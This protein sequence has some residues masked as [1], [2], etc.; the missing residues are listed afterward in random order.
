MQAL[1]ET[2]A[3]QLSADF[4]GKTVG[5][6][7]DFG[8]TLTR[9]PFTVYTYFHQWEDIQYPSINVQIVSEVF[10]GQPLECCGGG[11]MALTVDF[12]ITVDSKKHGYSI[13][14]SLQEALREW[15]CSVSGDDSLTAPTYTYIPTIEVPTSYH[16]YEGEVFSI[17]VVA[18]IHYLRVEKGEL[19]P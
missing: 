12:R 18:R 11:V 2:L 6:G 13:A 17:H 5:A 16:I 4:N 8:D 19:A 10:Q 15:L 7:G 1:V 9:G 3:T 14:A